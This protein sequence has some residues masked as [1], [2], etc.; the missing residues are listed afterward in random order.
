MNVAISYGPELDLA[1]PDVE[2]TFCNHEIDDLEGA[3]RRT[4]L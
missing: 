4:I 2:N 3:L 1:I